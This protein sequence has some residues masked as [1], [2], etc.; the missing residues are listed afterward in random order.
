MEGGGIEAQFARALALQ[1]A[2]KD[3]E[4]LALYDALALAR[5]DI[6]ALRLNR[7]A[8]LTALGRAKEASDDLALLAESSPS[9][10]GWNGLGNALRAQ[11]RFPEA[12]AAYRRAHD[13]TPDDP[14][15]ASNLGLACQ[16]LGELKEAILHFRSALAHDPGSAELKAHLGGALLMAGE[17]QEG[18]PAYE[19]RLSG[20]PALARMK[21]LGL[22]VW[23]GGDLS[24]RTL[25]LHAEQGLGDTLQ[26]LRFVPFARTRG[27]RIILSL[28]PALLR[29][30]R[31]LEGVEQVISWDDVPPPC[32]VQSPLLSLARLSGLSKPE[33]IPPT[34][35]TADPLLR[36]LWGQRM[37]GFKGLRIGLSWQGNPA[38]AAD[39]RRSIALRDFMALA[40]MEGVVLIS[41]QTGLGRDQIAGSDLIDL[42]GE[43]ADMA[44]AAAAME[45]LD[46]VISVDSGAAHLAGSLCRPVWTLVRVNPD[47]RWP[48]GART[49][50][51]YPSMRLFR[52]GKSGDWSDVLSQISQEIAQLLR[53]R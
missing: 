31:G 27:A 41:L 47:W 50:P 19:A 21:A 4:A 43:F 6:P 35:V 5:P 25:L 16:D 37:S 45:H 17:W 12:K 29:L 24:G 53:S 10:Q 30:A 3:A 39:A 26:F 20:T 9:P 15:I 49:T 2:G 1:Q 32:D 14:L 22:P 42:G 51:W 48:P 40:K 18:W 8:C 7:A 23:E 28:Q 44:D 36:E 33:A 38:M 11:G 34:S 46:L 52:Q 13:L